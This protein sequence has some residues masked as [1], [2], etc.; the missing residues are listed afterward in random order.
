MFNKYT[1]CSLVLLACEITL[2]AKIL[3]IACSSLSR[4]LKSSDFLKNKISLRTL[5]SQNLMAFFHIYLLKSR[6]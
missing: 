3:H 6:K 2:I 1:N 5:L 4:N